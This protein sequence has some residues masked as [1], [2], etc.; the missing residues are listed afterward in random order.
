MND[1]SFILWHVGSNQNIII[2]KLNENNQPN[3]QFDFT[4]DLFIG[5]FSQ[6]LY[7]LWKK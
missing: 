7:L 2:L 5:R 4:C 6:R 1:Y 3:T